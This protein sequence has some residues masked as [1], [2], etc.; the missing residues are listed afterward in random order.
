MT[1]W[2]STSTG[3]TSSLSKWVLTVSTSP[4]RMTLSSEQS[5]QNYCR[6][7]KGRKTN[8][9]LG[10]SGATESPAFSN[11][12]RKAQ[13]PSPSA[14]SATLLTTSK[15]PRQRYLPR[16]YHKSRTC[17]PPNQVPPSSS[18]KSTASKSGKGTIWLWMVT[19]TWPQTETSG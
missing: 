18:N 13:G 8:G 10:T 12:R 6:S 5:N 19:R 14:A 7:L 3:E 1:S 9:F 11:L 4:F 2:T 16:V 17:H 15:V